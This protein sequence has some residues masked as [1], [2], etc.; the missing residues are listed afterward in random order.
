MFSER[1]SVAEVTF[2]TPCIRV[3]PL[4]HLSSLRQRFTVCIHCAH[5]GNEYRIVSY[6]VRDRPNFVFVFGAEN[7]DLDWFRSF[8][9]SDEN[10]FRC[11]RLFRFRPKTQN[12]ILVGLYI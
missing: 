10:V 9:F 3:A 5:S 4:H 1:E 7:E 2:G 12:L 11:F 8:S 6:L